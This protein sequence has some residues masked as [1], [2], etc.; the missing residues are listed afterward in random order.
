MKPNWL[1]ST[2]LL[3]MC[4]CSLSEA[5]ATRRVGLWEGHPE[6]R[7]CIRQAVPTQVHYAEVYK[8]CLGLEEEDAQAMEC[9][10]DK[11][12]LEDLWQVKMC[13]RQLRDQ[14]A[15]GPANQ[16][17]ESEP[18]ATWAGPGIGFFGLVF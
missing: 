2:A 6:F 15:Y 11:T 12:P 17:P 8:A 9:V 7:A 1:L 13:Q 5:Q 4:G 3:L 10:K 18:S 14:V 16:R